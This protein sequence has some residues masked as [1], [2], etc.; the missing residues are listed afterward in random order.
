MPTKQQ[1]SPDS[2]APCIHTW[3]LP[4]LIVHKRYRGAGFALLLLLFTAS[5]AFAQ[6]TR[7]IDPDKGSGSTCTRSAPCQLV[8]AYKLTNADDTNFLIRVPFAGSTV[9]VIPPGEANKLTE[10]VRFGTYVQEKDGAVEGTIRFVRPS[11]GAYRAF[12]IAS[13]GQ[14]RLDAKATVEFGDI[15]VD[16]RA[17]GGTSGDIFYT[18]SGEQNRITVTGTLTLYQKSRLN[19][20]VVSQDMTIK[21]GNTNGVALLI[22]GGLTVKEGAILNLERNDDGGSGISLN[23]LFRKGRN[24]TDPRGLLTVD[25][26]I[27]RGAGL[28]DHYLVTTYL[29]KDNRAA[30]KPRIPTSAY[31]PSN[32]GVNHEDCIRIAGK[33]TLHHIELRLVALGNV[34]VDL[35]RVGNLLIFGSIVEPSGVT[36]KN[37][38]TDVIFRQDVIVD[39]DIHQWGDARTVFEKTATIRGNIKLDDGTYPTEVLANT[40]GER[41]SGSVRRGV[42][43]GGKGK[44]SCAYTPRGPDGKDNK[45]RGMHI[46]GMQFEDAV[47]IEG[48]LKVN[49]S[50]F[51]DGAAADTKSNAPACAPRV[52]FLAPLSGAT[53]RESVIKGALTVEDAADFADRGRVHLDADTTGASKAKRPKTVHNVRIEGGIS[54]QGNTIGMADPAESNVDGMC[55][56]KD[57]ELTF[58]N[59]I[60]F[61]GTDKQA[62]TGRGSEVMLDAVMALEDLDVSSGTL[63]VKT[64]H[65]G[66]RA[67]LMSTKNVKV[68]ESLILEGELNGELDEAS[69]IKRLTYGNRNTDVVK[70]AALTDMLDALAIHVGSGELHLDEAYE[71]KNLGLCSGTLSL[72]DVES[73]T[74]STLHVTEQITVQNGMLAKDTNDPGSIS[75]DRGKTANINDRYI[76][77][78]IT[79]GK[80]TVTDALEWFDPR[81]VI[82]N[83]ASAEITTS[84]DRSIV[85]K[86]TIT[87]GKLMVDGMLTVGTSPF[88]RTDATEVGRY[89]VLVTAGELHT[90]GQEVR[91]HG[92]VSVNGKSKLMTGG[93]DLHVLGRVQQGEYAS[94]TA[95]ATMS[96]RM[97]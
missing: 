17:I 29:G 4:H 2:P 18:P 31:D 66:P 26:T 13:G 36:E 54:A 79:P 56:T 60:I 24:P 70:K 15:E 58:G 47:T 72:A 94:N 22:V 40:D 81:D 83:H 12:W 86:L 59:H 51:T 27:Q 9:E 82:V 48:D 95:Q 7:Y 6:A 43:I 37:I 1:H 21:A 90:K 97:P 87:K 34:C 85:G 33:G 45:K 69:T 75:T 76:L 32:N 73:T 49:Y 65:V 84:G 78:Y 38:S 8:E 46:P 50:S 35:K 23:F 64:L 16:D 63:T 52:L 5:G 28:A 80:R 71:T 74:D 30:F 77:T 20:F 41:R 61:G 39:G 89:S 42:Q 92:K 62:V 53:T 67:E 88:H 91:V 25:G 68:T 55:M 44:F 96:Q 11:D 57:T 10:K 93:G 19:F 14:F 3:K